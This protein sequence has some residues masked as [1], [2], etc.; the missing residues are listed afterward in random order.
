LVLKEKDK[1]ISRQSKRIFQRAENQGAVLKLSFTAMGELLG[2]YLEL[3]QGGDVESHDQLANVLFQKE[4]RAIEQ[5]G[6]RAEH[7]EEML[8]CAKE[9]RQQDTLLDP[10]DVI[11]I[12]T[13]LADPESQ[14]LITFDR[15]ILDSI[16]AN[17]Y[18]S[19]RARDRVFQITD[20][21]W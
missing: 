15:R 9:I 13:A 20:N 17:A 3:G 4:L 5:Y 8:N 16:R 19:T 14:G 2:S 12:A 21:P 10:N 7:L 11:I 6:V 18:V 1:D